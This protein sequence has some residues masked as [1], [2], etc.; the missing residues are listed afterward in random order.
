MWVWILIWN[1]NF[2][3]REVLGQ[4]LEQVLEKVLEEVLALRGLL[5][6]YVAPVWTNIG[7][8]AF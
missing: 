5:V 8:D 3:G 2:R 6:E 7:Q 4:V 1:V